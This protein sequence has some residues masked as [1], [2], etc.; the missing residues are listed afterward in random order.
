MLNRIRIKGYKPLRDVDV[1]L[2]PLSVLLGPNAVGKSNFL[3]A[4]Q[5]LSKLVTSRTLKEAFDLPYRGKPLESFS[6]SSDGL[7]GLL[8]RNTVSFSIEVDFTLSSAV[9]E[10]VN[11]QAK[12]LRRST[13]EEGGS[14]QEDGKQ[15]AVRER[16]MR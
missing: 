1:K 9:V 16:S 8:A 4:L 11:R 5:L 2:Q 13:L 3:D 6:F 14:R 7:K 15:G 10:A 12:E